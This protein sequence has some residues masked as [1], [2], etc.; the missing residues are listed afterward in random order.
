MIILSY[1]PKK[2]K[3]NKQH[4]KSWKDSPLDEEVEIGREKM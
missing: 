4:E 1:K 3:E 2:M